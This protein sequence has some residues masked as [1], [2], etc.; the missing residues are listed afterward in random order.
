[1]HLSLMKARISRDFFVSS[2]CK[3]PVSQPEFK[4]KLM[5]YEGDDITDE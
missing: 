2:F 3:E 5:I 4:A 1:M